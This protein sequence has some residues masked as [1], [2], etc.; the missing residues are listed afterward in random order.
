MSDMEKANILHQLKTAFDLPPDMLETLLQQIS[1]KSIKDNF[2]RITTGLTIEDNYK[3]I[4]S[5]LPW[6]KNISGLHQAQAEKYKKDFQIPDYLLLVEDSQKGKFPLLIDVKYV[7]GDKTQ[8]SIIPKQKHTLRQ[9][10]AAHQQPLLIAI[11][12][13]RL[14]YWT[15]NCLSN[16]GGKK[17]NKIDWQTAIGNDLSHLLSDYTFNIDKPFYRR[18]IFPK[19]ADHSD[20]TRPR[21]LKYGNVDSVFLGKDIAHLYSEDEIFYSIVVDANFNSKIVSVDDHEDH[22]CMIEEFSTQPSMIKIS[23]WLMNVAQLME[24]EPS[25]A[26]H[27]MPALEMARIVTVDLMH[28]LEYSPIYILPNE[29]NACTDRLFELAYKDTTVMFEYLRGVV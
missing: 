20:R 15:H 22:V 7:K 12:W 27:E 9:Y 16:F 23:Q 24:I 1:S 21:H 13:E 19:P 28:K 5:S 14:G 25:L 11:Y 10:A 17:H 4:Y 8:C 29:K 2:K 26:V 6:I 18:T 3:H